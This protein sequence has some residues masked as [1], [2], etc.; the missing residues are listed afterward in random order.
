MKLNETSWPRRAESCGESSE[1]A[2]PPA[3]Y[4]E[5]HHRISH[6]K[7]GHTREDPGAELVLNRGSCYLTGVGPATPA[8]CL[9]RVHWISSL[10]FNSR[11]NGRISFYCAH[12]PSA[13]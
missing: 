6:R 11:R 9:E 10:A 7:G 4:L 2:R 8:T 1:E 3:C 12:R 13:F 5:E